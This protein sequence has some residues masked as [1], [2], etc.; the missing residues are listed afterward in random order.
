MAM[1]L[2]KDL[3]IVVLNMLFILFFALTSQIAMS[4]PVVGP[5]KVTHSIAEVPILDNS[6]KK[7]FVYRPTVVEPM[8]EELYNRAGMCVC[9]FH[10]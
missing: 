2:K 8:S 10:S 3:I 4:Q 9:F 7:A 1:Q 6:T 5:Y